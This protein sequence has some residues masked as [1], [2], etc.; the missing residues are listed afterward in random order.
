MTAPPAKPLGRET[1]RTF[2][3][4]ALAPEIKQAIAAYLQPLKKLASGI[5]W[6]KSENLHLTLKFLGDTPAAQIPEMAAAMAAICARY[7]PVAAR[8]SGSGFF[9]NANKPRVLWLAVKTHNDDLARLAQ[10]IDNAC[11]QW[12]FR[13]EARPFAPHLTVARVRDGAAAAVVASMQER[14]FSSPET[15]LRECVFMKSTLQAG[16]SFY[17]PLHRLRLSHSPVQNKCNA[18]NL[19][20]ERGD[21]GG[22]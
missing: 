20:Q 10:E 2:I 19:N 16:G 22:T 5:A 4:L 18:T 12:G 14:Q 21:D 17:T 15:V 13:K 11:A 6:V 3:A 8:I 7:Q 9:P 1:V